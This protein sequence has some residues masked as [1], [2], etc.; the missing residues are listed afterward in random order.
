[1][2]LLRER[3]EGV[4][5]ILGSS[6][7]R[8][9]ELLTSLDIPFTIESG[10]ESPE[11]IS[12]EIELFSIPQHLSLQKSIHFHR[13]LEESELLITADTLVFL[14]GEILGKPKGRE[15]AQNMLSML[16]GKSHTVIT[17]ITL[18]SGE[19]RESFSDRSEVC[20][21]RIW[22][23]EIDYYIDR[24]KPYDKAGAYG[25]QEWIGYSAIKSIKGS[26]YNVMGL[27]TALLYEKLLL[28]V[29]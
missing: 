13:A 28:F 6:S 19:K 23:N 11:V 29:G 22:Q 15:E 20:F 27:P 3:V 25:V 9:E 10:S 8:R 17:G 2:E 26:Y 12:K 7:P 14:E 16:S 21:R 18:R 24:Y 1:V 4:K 5:I